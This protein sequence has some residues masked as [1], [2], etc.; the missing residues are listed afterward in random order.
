VAIKD[1]TGAGYDVKRII[2]VPGETVA[3]KNGQVY[4]NGKLLR[5]P[6]LPPRTPTYLF[7]KSANQFVCFVQRGFFVM[8]DNRLNSLDSRAFGEIPRHDILGRIQ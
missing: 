5:E 2:A 1:P 8:G 4:I 3:F 6:Y 7:G